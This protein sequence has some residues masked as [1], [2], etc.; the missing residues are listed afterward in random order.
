MTATFVAANLLLRRISADTR[1]LLIDGDLSNYVEVT[2]RV[3][4][5]LVNSIDQV[6]DLKSL[7]TLPT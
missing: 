2:A 1:L 7:L 6:R 3:E 5:Y 4:S